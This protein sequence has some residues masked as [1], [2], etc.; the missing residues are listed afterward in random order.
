MPV[1]IVDVAKVAK[2]SVSTA[3][4][5]IRDNV[6]PVATNTREH[7]RTVA[8]QLGYRPNLRARALRSGMNHVIAIGVPDRVK[9]IYH[10]PYFPELI[11]GA[12]NA[13]DPHGFSLTFPMIHIDAVGD[14]NG[15][16]SKQRID[17]LAVLAPALDDPVMER[18]A[19]LSLPLVLIGRRY[20]Y[21]E[22]PWVDTDNC[23]ATKKMIK[24]MLERGLRKIAF[25]HSMSNY[26]YS[27]DRIKGYH[28]ALKESGIEPRQED[29]Y[30]VETAVSGGFRAIKK[31]LRQKE[32][33]HGIFCCHST[34]AEGAFW[35]L[36]QANIEIPQEIAFATFD[37]PSFASYCIPTITSVVQPVES[38][39]RL[40]V[41]LLLDQILGRVSR[42][43]I[44]SMPEKERVIDSKIILR[45][46]I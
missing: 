6:G 19:S 34:I 16:L 3:S 12:V 45:S 23:Q 15:P 42:D 46:S 38:I 11:E 21:P 2:V 5:A 27:L 14:E 22:I 8:K 9:K 32:L 28:D 10:D 41:K 30:E 31:I 29:I 13:T 1:T 24:M 25:I 4:L 36:K 40:A 35:A 26:Q 17:G 18:L 39:G 33:P 43:D 20:D 37:D 44:L 7:I